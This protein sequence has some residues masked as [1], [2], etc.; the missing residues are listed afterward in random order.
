MNGE[1]QLWIF[2]VCVGMGVVGGI[3]HLPF[4]VLARV[5]GVGE[6][7]RKGI[8]I[9]IDIVYFLMLAVGSV[10]I[11]YALRFPDFRVYQWFGYA[12]G[13]IIYLKILH[14]TIAFFENIWY[15]KLSK[16]IKKA[17][18]RRNTLRKRRTKDYDAR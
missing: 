14:K 15:N 11:T 8:G 6:N 4:R 9:A 13:G 12:I 7:K 5:C 17:K 1:N 10:W 3:L 2:L 16:G 18:N